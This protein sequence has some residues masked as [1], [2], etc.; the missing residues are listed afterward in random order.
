M[1][2]TGTPTIGHALSKARE[3]D[4]GK[5]LLRTDTKENELWYEAVRNGVHR[6][7]NY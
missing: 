1:A 4:G 2:S 5:N 6:D 7:A 3:L